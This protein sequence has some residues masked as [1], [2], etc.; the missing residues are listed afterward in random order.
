M[1]PVWGPENEKR[2]VVRTGR[3]RGTLGTFGLKLNGVDD[4]ELTKQRV[5]TRHQLK[6]PSATHTP[7]TR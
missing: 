4:G 5:K 6:E 3:K 2:R 7:P 1:G